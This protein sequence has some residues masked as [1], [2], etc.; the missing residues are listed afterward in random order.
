MARLPSRFSRIFSMG[1]PQYFCIIL[2]PLQWAFQNC[3]YM[4]KMSIFWGDL[5][6]FK[7]YL[8]KTKIW[9]LPSSDQTYLKPCW[10]SE[11]A[12]FSDSPTDPTQ[13]GWKT[14]PT[15]P[16]VKV[17]SKLIFTLASSAQTFPKPCWGFELPLFS[18]ST[19]DLTRPAD[20]ESFF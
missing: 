4:S 19:T 8:W 7:V 5:C 9:L 2:K 14:R 11:L 20:H 12:L 3:S 10:G 16:T 18:D 13:P 17:F 6:S 15:R 1:H